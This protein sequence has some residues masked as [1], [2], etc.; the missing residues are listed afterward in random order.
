L[1]LQGL[2]DL[3]RQSKEIGAIQERVQA[4]TRQGQI[5]TGLSGGQRSV[6]LSTIYDPKTGYVSGNL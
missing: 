3:V 4:K 2:V 6:F 5:I 1:S